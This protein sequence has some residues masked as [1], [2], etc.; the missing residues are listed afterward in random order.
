MITVLSKT[1]VRRCDADKIASGIP[2]AEL[3]RRAAEGIA[4]YIGINENTAVICGPGNNGGDGYA[5]AEILFDRGTDCTVFSLTDR[6]SPDGESYRNKCSH[7]GVKSEIF[8]ESTDLSGFDTVVDCI[9]GTGF[10]GA[11]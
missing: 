2:G 5:L 7:K 3:M 8:D 9:F 4:Q 10:K 11:P 1:A 6:T